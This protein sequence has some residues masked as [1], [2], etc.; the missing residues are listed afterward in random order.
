M[1]RIASHY[2][3]WKKWFRMHYLELDAEGCFVGVYPLEQEIANTEFYDG[4]LI[5]IPADAT[6]PVDE[7]FVPAQWVS[8][9]DKVTEGTLVSV[10]RLTHF[11]PATSELGAD[12]CGS[13]CHIQRL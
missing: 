10:F 11:T 9:A 5:P 1:R 2:I 8:V 6:I 13:D 3:Y 12:D 7:G 4:T